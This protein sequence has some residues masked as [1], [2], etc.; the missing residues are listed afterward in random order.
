LKR[1]PS[2]QPVAAPARTAEHRYHRTL[3]PYDRVPIRHWQLRQFSRGKQ[4]ENVVPQHPGPPPLAYAWW[5][6]TT[7][8]PTWF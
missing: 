1:F 4:T 7:I 3:P 5:R 2:R 6:R 8:E